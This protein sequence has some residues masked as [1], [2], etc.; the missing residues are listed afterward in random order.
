MVFVNCLNKPRIAKLVADFVVGLV[1]QVQE[2]HANDLPTDP[3]NHVPGTYN[4]PSGAAYYFTRSGQQVRQMP[5]YK[6]DDAARRNKANQKQE[7]SKLFPQVS[8][9]GY[10][11]LMVFFCPVHGHCYGFH[12]IAGG[13]GPK[14]VLA[15]LLKFLPSAP[16]H[17]FY[18]FACQLSEYCHNREPEF[19]KDT[20]FWHDIFHSF[21]HTGCGSAHKSS[22]VK[23]MDHV[24]SE[25]C[26]Q[27]NAYLQCIKFTGSHLTQKHFMLFCQFMVYLWNSEKTKKYKDF[28]RVALAGVL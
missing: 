10:G 25:I 27:F 26:E 17:M 16:K 24:N 7:C 13:E 14:D 8:F 11:Y 3:P 22:R 2:V 4:P 28:V 12:L 23:G 20:R 19:F 18:D 9:G 5:V 1:K 15:A 21:N 6:A